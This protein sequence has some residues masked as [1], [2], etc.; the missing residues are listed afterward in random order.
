[1]NRGWAFPLESFA[2]TMTQ[3]NVIDQARLLLAGKCMVEKGFTWTLRPV[4]AETPSENK[5]VFAFG[6]GM[7]SEAQ[8][9][10][11]AIPPQYVPLKSPPEPPAQF[12]DAYYE[13]LYGPVDRR[14]KETPM[15]IGD[16]RVTSGVTYT[17]DSC[18]GV[19]N[20]AIG[21][22]VARSR[23]L[24]LSTGSPEV[25]RL[26]EE[27]RDRTG[28]DSR[29][30]QVIQ[31]WS[32]C[33]A[34]RGFT[35]ADPIDAGGSYDTPD[36]A[37]AIAEATADVECKY[38]TNYFG[39]MYAVTVEHQEALIDEGLAGLETLAAENEEILEKAN[40]VIQAG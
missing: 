17:A 24:F 8:Q 4:Q 32:V 36:N 11:Y 20:E 38:E 31:E 9:Y 27:A 5:L 34:A 26:M 18:T 6:I 3:L 14:P 35:I 25:A 40:A 30:V 29:V 22:S 2:L 23:E 33:M 19:A 37:T 16:A 10:G 21:L 39:V 13:T 7:L 1:M 15:Q 12:S 28:A